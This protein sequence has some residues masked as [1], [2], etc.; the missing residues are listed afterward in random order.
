MKWNR[1]RV[2][3]VYLEINLKFVSI[4]G[5]NATGKS[6]RMTRVIDSLGEVCEPILIN[7]NEEGRIYPDSGICIIGN[8]TKTGKW[9]SMD[10]F[11]LTSWTDRI[12]FFKGLSKDP[13]L[14]VVLIEGY[15]N[16]ITKASNLDSWKNYGFDEAEYIFMFYD[17]VEEF[18]ARVN[19]RNETKGIVK[20]LD[21]AINSAGWKNNEGSVKPW[22]QN[23]LKMVTE[24][25]KCTR[26]KYDDDEYYLVDMLGLTRV[27]PVE[28]TAPIKVMK[29][30]ST[31][32]LSEFF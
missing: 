12:E 8:R 2:L 22:Y 21:W 20:D 13:R 3:T 26:L 9:V 31:G 24:S 28:Y 11:V 6:T 29:D 23:N 32:S 5:A 10:S 30:S 27:K 17:T 15:F 1:N 7:G 16:M 18:C 14:K 19:V 4:I 25:T